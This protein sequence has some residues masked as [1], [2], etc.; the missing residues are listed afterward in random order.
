MTKFFAFAF[1]SLVQGLLN[2]P[3]VGSFQKILLSTKRDSAAAVT[4]SSGVM[5]LC[6]AAQDSIGSLESASSS[7][8]SDI[9]H[10]A[11][12]A[13]DSAPSAVYVS[14][15]SSTDTCLW[16]S[17]CQCLASSS[18]CLGGDRWTSVAISDSIQPS[19]AAVVVTVG[20]PSSQAALVPSIS[21][22][23]ST[24]Q[25]TPDD[26]VPCDYSS[27]S[28]MQSFQSKCQMK[29]TMTFQRIVA[30]SVILLIVILVSASFGVAHYFD[31][32]ELAAIKAQVR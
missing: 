21:K 2:K 13:H 7:G 1:L 27:S 28:L 31:S 11:Q 19:N 16:F 17:N 20:G 15:S 5:G 30:G 18:T 32:V 14:F 23:S 22:S 9:N 10:C 4:P 29:Q 8:L 6:S 12:Y 25:S 3:I 26:D 24:R